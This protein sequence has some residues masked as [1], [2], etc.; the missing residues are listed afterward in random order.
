ME[1]QENVSLKHLISDWKGNCYRE[2]GYSVNILGTEW[3]VKVVDEL[4]NPDIDGLCCNYNKTIYL[5]NP[6]NYGAYNSEEEYVRF[7][8][9][10]RH[11]IIHAFVYESGIDNIE[12]GDEQTTDWLAYQFDKIKKVFEMLEI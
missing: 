12:A 6:N 5:I 9:I 11:E 7:K 10:I 4:S 8:L 1:V 2:N 3:T